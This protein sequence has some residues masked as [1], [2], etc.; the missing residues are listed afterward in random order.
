MVYPPR[1]GKEIA[2]NMSK[3]IVQQEFCWGSHMLTYHG[4][5]EKARNTT[6]ITCFG[7][8][9]EI[10]LMLQEW[11]ASGN[12]GTKSLRFLK[13]SQTLFFLCCPRIHSPKRRNLQSIQITSHS[14]WVEN[15]ILTLIAEALSSS[16]RK[17]FSGIYLPIKTI[18]LSPPSQPNSSKEWF[19]QDSLSLS[20]C[21]PVTFQPTAFWFSFQP[22]ESPIPPHHHNSLE[23]VPSMVA[24]GLNIIKIQVLFLFCSILFDL[25][26]AS[27]IWPS[28]FKFSLLLV[29]VTLLSIHFISNYL[30]T[31]SQRFCKLLFLF[32]VF[33]GRCS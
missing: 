18:L 2:R 6:R 15:K 26:W 14:Q 23:D 1:R 27:D 7:P 22:L 9:G 11:V 19:S 29:S 3:R 12:L 24:S 32:P 10:R 25:P 4:N 17:P 5:S 21:L 28:F 8:T 16:S 31:P 33:K 20:T 30:T 13:C